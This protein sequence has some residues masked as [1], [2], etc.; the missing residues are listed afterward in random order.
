[1]NGFPLAIL[2]GFPFF[3]AGVWILV[4]SLLS[5]ASGWRRLAE[6][7]QHAGEFRGELHRGQSAR[8]RGVNF[9]RVLEIGV[10]EEGLYL[11]PMVLFRLFHK[12]LLIPWGEIEAEPFR[13]FLYQGVRL[14]F[15][16]V[17][18]VP[19]ELS[20]RDYERFMEHRAA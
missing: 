7:Y 17:H 19:L 4:M 5:M 15:R 11:V 20:K 3:F 13:R 8:L 6:S 12:P 14:T 10:G 18:G 2:V 9:N 1:M 16:S